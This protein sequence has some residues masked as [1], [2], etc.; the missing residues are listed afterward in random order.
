[1]QIDSKKKL[2]IFLIAKELLNDWVAREAA[3]KAIIQY[4]GTKMTPQGDLWT[5]YYSAILRMVQSE[6]NRREKSRAQREKLLRN[7]KGKSDEQV[8]EEVREM[9]PTY[10][11]QKVHQFLNEL[12][13]CSQPKKTRMP[14]MR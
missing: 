1:M 14:K 8:M 4:F 3:R 5:A 9:H 7:F 6:E 11:A 10:N 2:A 13:G 12:Y